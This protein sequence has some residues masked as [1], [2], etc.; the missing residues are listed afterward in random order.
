VLALIEREGALL[1]ERRSD[2]G[3][4]GLVGGA[5]EPEEALGDALR[6]EVRE[7][8][9][10]TVRDLALFGVFSDPSRIARYPDGNTIR[11]IA[12]AYEAAVD[13]FEGL[14]CSGESTALEFFCAEE[15]ARLDVIETARPIVDLYASSARSSAPF[16][17][18]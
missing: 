16:V 2:C 1:M 5:V 10:L 7:E 11:I 4:W 18:E 12:F 15:L 6:R 13:D 14:R 3:R 17:V 8:T 9:G